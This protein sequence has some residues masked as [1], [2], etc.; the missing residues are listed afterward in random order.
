MTPVIGS[1]EK[2]FQ[3]AEIA[4]RS[5]EPVLI[6]G[7]T[8]VGK[9]VLARYIHE[10][11]SRRER[12]FMPINCAAVPT[13]LL[14]SEL[15]GYERGA[16]TGATQSRKGTLERAH[17]GTV[18][19]DEVVEI[20]LEA[21]AKLLRTIETKEVMPLGSHQYRPIDVRFIA[22][23]NADIKLKLEKGEFRRDLYY[24]LSVF[25]YSIPPL[26]ER[27]PDIPMLVDSFVVEAGKTVSLS[28][29]AQ[30]LLMCYHWPGNAREVRNVI[31]YAL[32]KADSETI[33]VEHLP[34]YIVAR[35]HRLDVLSGTDLREKTE[36]FEARLLE[37]TMREQPDPQAA[38]KQLGL[39]LRTF[40][41]KLKKYGISSK[42]EKKE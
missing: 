23:T 4:A 25:F 37:E 36:C 15:F 7:E 24:R 42:P 39:G 27:M 21:Q 35:C 6:V 2:I 19:L 28:P 5:N 18:L 38:A 11:S 8:G 3:D 34:E 26:R 22:A 1:L 29:A 33:S 12:S 14:E 13:H 20:P 40:Y 41:R 10:R 32:A 9:E 30:E 31:N 17:G 16:F